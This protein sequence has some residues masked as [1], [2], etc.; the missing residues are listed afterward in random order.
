MQ[1]WG[2][3]LTAAPLLIAAGMLGYGRLADRLDWTKAAPVIMLVVVGLIFTMRLMHQVWMT[4]LRSRRVTAPD[5]VL[6][7]LTRFHLLAWS[8]ADVMAAS[9]MLLLL[10]GAPRLYG[11]SMGAIGLMYLMIYTPRRALYDMVASDGEPGS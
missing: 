7:R 1:L 2:R 10:I 9:G 8:S 5:A 6:G 4:P 11:Y 3:F